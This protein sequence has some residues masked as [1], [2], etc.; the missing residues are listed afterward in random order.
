V[1]GTSGSIA[2]E[3]GPV[4]YWPANAGGNTHRYFLVRT[5]VP[6]EQLIEAIRQQVYQADPRQS[7]GNVATLDQLL[8]DST[9]QPRLN[10]YV[11]A[12]FAGIALLLACVG[13][14]GV[15]AW[16]AAQRRHEIGVR[17]A[18]GATRNQIARLFV[19]RAMLPAAVGLLAGIALSLAAG[20]LLRSQL[21]GVQPDD[22]GL[23]AAS[24]VALLL[25][26]LLATL[27]PALRAAKTDPMKALRTE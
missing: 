6:P 24:V 15:V 14:Y 26:V 7:I 17:M 4:V 23:Y 10:V 25:P 27:R 19:R 1:R 16:F 20:R 21:Y 22:P 18:L 12:S 11:A 9:A 5:K 2:A 8:G 3:P 13:I